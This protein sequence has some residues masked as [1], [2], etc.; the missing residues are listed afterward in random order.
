MKLYRNEGTRCVEVI[1]DRR[2]AFV[3][4][5]APTQSERQG[6][7]DED[8]TT[9]AHWDLRNIAFFGTLLGLVTL[10]LLLLF[11]IFNPFTGHSVHPSPSPSHAAQQAVIAPGAIKHSP[12]TL[13]DVRKKRNTGSPQRIA[14]PVHVP[15]P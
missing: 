4:L 14:P 12:F 13:L 1:Y 3:F 8:I 15:H 10:D 9:A 6:K 7:L 11:V 5:I 2:P